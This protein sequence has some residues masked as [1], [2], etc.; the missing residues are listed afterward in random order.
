MSSSNERLFLLED[1]QY[2]VCPTEEKEEVNKTT[3]FSFD[4]WL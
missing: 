4:A 1:A 3:R 2:F